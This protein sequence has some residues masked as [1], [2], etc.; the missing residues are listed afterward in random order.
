MTENNSRN[1]TKRIITIL[2]LFPF[3]GSALFG[4]V[5]ML[6]NSNNSPSKN[7]PKTV[8]AKSKE[9]LLKDQERGYQ[10]V[11]AREPNNQI[12]LEGLVQIRLAMNNLPGVV[13]PMEKLVKLNPDR[14][15][16]KALLAEVKKRAGNEKQENKKEK[17][18]E[19]SNTK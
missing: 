7:D 16:Y 3:V 13:E 14:P 4:F 11:L 18:G 9:T 10:K 12:A 6:A 17:G 1:K 8:E 19:R 2:S 15:E 5:G